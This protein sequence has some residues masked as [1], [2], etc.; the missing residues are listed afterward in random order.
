MR[1]FKNKAREY[2]KD[3]IN[4]PAKNSK[5]INIRELFKGVTE[6]KKGFQPASNLN[7]G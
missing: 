7:K 2:L 6:F 3:K 1:D 4:E 5:N